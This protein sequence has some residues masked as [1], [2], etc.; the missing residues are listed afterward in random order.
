M[1]SIKVL[2]IDMLKKCGVLRKPARKILWGLRKF[3]YTVMTFRVKQ[4]SRI[5][6]FEVF[7]GR[8]YSCNPRAI[9]E[10][11]LEDCRFDGVKFVWAFEDCGK[12]DI[13]RNLDRA[14]VIRYGSREYFKYAAAAGV[15]ITNSNLDFR[16]RKR[17]GQIFI[18]TWHGTPLKKL[19]CDITAEKGS[20]INSLSEIIH[21]NNLDMDR[22]DYLISPS[23]FCTEKFISAFNLK[24]LGKENI[25]IET[26]YPRNDRLIAANEE[27]KKLIKK[28]IGI[29]DSK[30]VILYAPTFRDNEHDSGSGY[31]YNLHIDF[32]KLKQELGEEYVIIFR[33]HYFVSNTFDFERYKGFIYDESQRDDITDL[34]IVSDMLVTDY[35]SALFDFANLK[36]KI[37]FYMY[38]LEKYE[39]DIRGFYFSVNELPGRIVKTQEDL[40]DAIEAHEGEYDDKC[41]RFNKKF[42]LLNDGNA[43][44]RVAEIVIENL[45]KSGK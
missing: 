42:N 22:Y 38:D 1:K 18:Q 34:Y 12:K 5:I 30:K 44:A 40:A 4:D 11:M 7:M 43:G 45:E 9:Y 10:R 41:K 20:A 39:N 15:L 32:D 23:S 8:Q 29:A 25:I 13:F 16:I 37:I 17:K 14:E 28:E 24:T 35:S 27:E 6:L 33:A 26:G 21:K 2:T 19:R 36:R 3:L 31:I